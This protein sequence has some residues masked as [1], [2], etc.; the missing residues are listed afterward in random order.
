[1]KRREMLKS[2]LAASAAAGLAWQ[3]IAYGETPGATAGK[4]GS[5][6][7]GGITEDRASWVAMLDRICQP[8]F[9]ALSRRQLKALMPVEAY[10]GER[11]HRKQTTYLEAL[12]RALA[13]MAPWLEHGA[14]TGVE[15]EIRARY[16]E[17]A[18]A[19]IAAGVD[20][21][22]PDYMDFGG[23]RAERRCCVSLP[24]DTAGP[25]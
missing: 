24:G 11:E 18:R 16:C 19:A 12:G 6:S 22:S 10:A 15:G 9:E 7:D 23:D 21:A 20:K 25:P 8:V 17:W 1:M 5:V 14:A 4:V 13:G 3:R 2:G